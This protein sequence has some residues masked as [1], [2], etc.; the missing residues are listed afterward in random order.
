MND[1]EYTSAEQRTVVTKYLTA[2]PTK[3]HETLYPLPSPPRVGARAPF[4]QPSPSP[5]SPS[6]DLLARPR[7]IF[8]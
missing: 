8:S 7:V 5:D 6:P 2:V 3:V 1:M 4:S